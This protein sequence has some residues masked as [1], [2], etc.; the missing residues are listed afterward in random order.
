MNFVSWLVRMNNRKEKHI[1]MI[2]IFQVRCIFYFDIR[3]VVKNLIQVKEIQHNIVLYQTTNILH[4]N[5]LYNRETD[6]QMSRNSLTQ[7]LFVTVFLVILRTAS[8]RGGSDVDSTL[9]VD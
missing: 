6:W 1:F 4:K 3:W 7:S 9:Q 8:R 5:R 2:W